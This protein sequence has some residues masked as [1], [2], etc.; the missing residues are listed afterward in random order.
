GG[1]Y[2]DGKPVGVA[3][4]AGIEADATL[5]PIGQNDATLGVRPPALHDPAFSFGAKR[6]GLARRRVLERHGGEKLLNVDLDGQCRP[7]EWLGG[8][9]V[10]LT[11]HRW[12]DH[13]HPVGL[14][15][16]DAELP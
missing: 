2:V 13:S 5:R 1:S 10:G 9:R 12:A 6:G 3:I 15:Q 4:V 14:Q 7:T 8:R 11:W 16:L